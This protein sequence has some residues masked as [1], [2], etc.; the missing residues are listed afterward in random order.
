M[1]QHVRLSEEKAE[2]PRSCKKGNTKQTFSAKQRGPTR[3]LYFVVVFM[4]GIWRLLKKHLGYFAWTIQD[5]VSAG[6][7]HQ[8]EKYAENI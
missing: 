8:Q 2:M 3:S 1:A 7:V 6:L 4:W 5:V